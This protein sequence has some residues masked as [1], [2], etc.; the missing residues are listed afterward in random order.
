MFIYVALVVFVVLQSTLIVVVGG[1]VCGGDVSEVVGLV[2]R[3]SER[4]AARCRR[5]RARRPRPPLARA[6]CHP[7]LDLRGNDPLGT[8]LEKESLDPST[9][10]KLNIYSV[11]AIPGPGS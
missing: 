2:V 6:C 10:S 11:T 4:A 1:A 8:A 5:R 3:E 7:A 9:G